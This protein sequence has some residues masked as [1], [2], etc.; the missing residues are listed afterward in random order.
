MDPMRSQGV[1]RIACVVILAAHARWSAAQSDIPDSTA[2]AIIAHVIARRQAV[3]TSMAGCRYDAFVK[4]AAV[5][6][7]ASPDS[8]RSVLFLTETRASVYWE[9]PDRYQEIIEARHRPNEGGLG[10]APVSVDEIVHFEWDHIALVDGVD[11]SRMRRTASARSSLRR[12]QGDRYDVPLPVAAGALDNYDFVVRDSVVME[13]RRVIEVTVHPRSDGSPRFAGTVAVADSS[14]D[15]VAMDLGV[16]A[17][18]RF[19]GVSDLQYHQHLKDM[20]NG[21]WLPTEIRL[22]GHVERKIS[23]RWLPRTVAG[24]PIPEFPRSVAFEEVAALSGYDFDP[25]SRPPDLVEYRAVLRDTADQA[26][27]GTWSEPGAVP[28]TAAERAAWAAGDSAQHHPSFVPLVARDA[29]AVQRVAFGPGSV[30][31]NRV[32]GFYLGAAHDWRVNPAVTLTTRLGYALGRKL[33]QYR[34]GARLMLWAPQ[35]VWVGAVYHDETVAWPALTPA[36][37]DATASAFLSRVDPSE[38]YRDHGLTLS[39]GTKLI[40][41]TR[42]ELRYEDTHQ[43]SLDTLPGLGFR[44][45]RFPPLPN[46]PIVDGHLRSLSGTVTYDSRRLIRSWGVDGRIAGAAWTRVSLGVEIGA[47]DILASDFSFRRYTLQLEHQ[48]HV[49]GLGVTTLTLAGGVATHF[50]PPQQYFTVGYGMQILAAEGRSFNTLARAQYAGNRALA[51]LLRHDFGHVFRRIP[52]SLS[53]HGGVFWAAL[54]GNV[55]VPS[56]S[57]LTAANRPY[58]EAGFTLGNLT[59][60]LSP[61]DLAASFTWQLSTYPTSRFRLGLGLIGL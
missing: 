10:R 33:W 42:L 49:G 44:S 13:G 41:F 27:T 7:Q 16:N 32:D 4:L 35:Q 19:P 55:V 51:V 6:L 53:L 20:G 30:H 46:P 11:L 59:P 58:A 54:R 5:D 34:G 57:L 45:T 56:D 43:S 12:P 24:M 9:P 8:A 2:R 25:A 40:D 37:Y 14:F 29:D 22:T 3:L 39:A 1:L 21:W 50:A 28:L 26:D 61:I 18:V 60:F 52:A 15:L 47:H 48:Q 17:A 31:F 38:Y 23:A 36:G